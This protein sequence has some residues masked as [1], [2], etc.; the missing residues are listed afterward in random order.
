MLKDILQTLLSR[1]LVALLNLA[2]IFINA[3]VLG[4]EGVGRAGLIWA[5]VS[6]NV[7]VCG[8]FSGNTLVYFLGRYSLGLLYPI[9]IGWTFAG[10]ALGCAL[11]GLT[12]LLPGNY[13]WEI[14]GLTILYSLS[15][16]HSR[17]LLGKN[18]IRGFNLTNLLQGGCLFFILLFFYFVVQRRDLNAYI[19]GLYLTN[20]V[21]FLVGLFLL[22][23]C[24]KR[25]GQ[26]A[27]G[28]NNLLRILREMLVYGLWGSADNI[29]E[30]CT[31]RLNYFLVERFAGP[32][33]VG[34]L[35]AATKISESVWHISR[36]AAYIAYNRIA[37]TKDQ[38]E[39]R[40]I[41]LEVLRFTFPALVVATSAILFLPE[42]FY[43]GYLFGREFEGVRGVI[44]A[45]SAGIVALGCHTVL[46]H[47][48]IGSGRIKYSAAASFIG[49]GVLTI[50]A[51]L[52][53]PAYGITGSALSTSIAYMAM[54]LFSASTFLRN[55]YMNWK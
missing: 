29:A 4:I 11:L 33:G 8:I 37:G 22:L 44:A 49:L 16:A 2:L 32:V 35:D 50:T 53:I 54:L 55:Y 9:A 43:T 51:F 20:G 3:R 17:F 46:S 45:L 36:S 15:V 31:T 40:R 6:I 34:L 52:L 27:P 30:T 7:S 38:R 42:E 21:S 12:G 5:S 19:W 26:A 1:Y 25:S 13:G 14:L 10:S 28:R 23:P 24:L 18:R 47:Y 39:Q 41:T 48:F